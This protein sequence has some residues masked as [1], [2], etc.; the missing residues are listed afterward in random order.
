MRCTEL[1]PI[2]DRNGR[3]VAW[4]K[5]NVLFN[6]EGRAVAFRNNNS[7]VSYRA[8]HLGVIDRGFIRDRNGHAV[9][10]MRGASGGPVQ[11]VPQVPPVPRVPQVPPVPPVPPIPP[12]PAVPSLSWSS[13]DWESFLNQ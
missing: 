2:F 4:F 12:V 8:R 7:I 3:T 9:A 10:F 13:M 1:E 5:E 6:L 11:P